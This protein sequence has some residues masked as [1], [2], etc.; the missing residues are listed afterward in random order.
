MNTSGRPDMDRSARRGANLHGANPRG[1]ALRGPAL[2]VAALRVAALRR[3]DDAAAVESYLAEVTARLPG[4]AR[5]SAGIVAELRSGLLD[6]TDARRSAGLP[7]EQ[8]ALAAIAEFGNPGLV[9]DGFRTEL[10]ARQARHVSVSLAAAGPLVGLLWITAAFASHLG[11]QLAPHGLWP[12]LPPVLRAGF[13]LVALVIAAEAWAALLG[14]AATGR[15]S[16]WLPVRPRRAPTAAVV[17]GFG[18]AGADIVMLSLLAAQLAIAPGQLSA[19]P[20]ALAA[21][22]SCVRLILATRAAHRC[23]ATRAALT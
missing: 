16:R 11:I 10:A 18:A 8:A 14:I 1:P 22:A 6:A 12:N 7:A 23:L 3:P 20:I 9:A 15:L 13:C 21:A 2:R 17:A 4:P 19:L 5:A